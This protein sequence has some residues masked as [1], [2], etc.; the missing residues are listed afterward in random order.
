MTWGD[1]D[2][3]T[4][5]VDIPGGSYD[6]KFVVQREGGSRDDSDWEAG[7]NRS[8]FVS[9]L[10]SVQGC[11]CLTTRLRSSPCQ[12]AGIAWVEVSREVNCGT[13]CGPCFR[14]LESAQAARSALV[15]VGRSLVT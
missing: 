8:L 1:G 15:P 5:E 7:A 13:A 10:C 2:N 6:F 9:R 3:W 4:L 14:V 12:D 11:C